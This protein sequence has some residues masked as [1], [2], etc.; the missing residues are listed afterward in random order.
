VVEHEGVE[1]PDPLDGAVYEALGC[2]WVSE[3]G[4]RVR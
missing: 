4:L 3:V 1:S 2:R